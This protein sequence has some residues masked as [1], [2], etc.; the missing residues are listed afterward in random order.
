L[1]VLMKQ[2]EDTVGMAKDITYNITEG[3]KGVE[4]LAR[5]SR[6]LTHLP[7]KRRLLYC[8]LSL[9]AYLVLFYYLYPIIGQPV[10]IFITIPIIFIPL[11]FGLWP[12]LLLAFVLCFLINPLAFALLTD[13]GW[14][15]AFGGAPMMGNLAGLS[16]ALIIAMLRNL[17]WD[18]DDLNAQQI[19]LN[20]ELQL[21]TNKYRS[22]VENVGDIILSCT[23][24]GTV[25]YV[26]PNVV[27]IGYTTEQ[28]IDRGLQEF[29][30]PD[31]LA[32]VR[33]D[34]QTTML[35]GNELIA[36]FRLKTA[37]NDYRWF[38]EFGNVVKETDDVVLLHGV[39]RD[40]TERKRA[41]DALR[42]SEGKYRLLA[43]NSADVIM[44]MDMNLKPS[45]ISPSIQRM[46][47]YS[48]EEAL[49][50]HLEGRITPASIEIIMKSFSVG[51][52]KEKQKTGSTTSETLELEAIHKNGSR[53]WTEMAVSFIR[54]SDGMAI[55]VLGTMRDITERK[56]MEEALRQAAA[57]WRQTFD[58]ISDA[59]SIHSKDCRLQRVNM[60]FADTFRM[61]PRG[62]IGKHC[63]E[64]M[65][66]T[67]EPIP[68]CPHQE[69]L[70]TGKPARAEFFEPKLGIHLE[71]T[72]SPIFDERGE[73]TGTVHIARDTT[74][75]K[76]QS[77]QLMMTDRLAS[78]GELAAGAAHELNNPL[79]S[80][81]GFSQLL[82][83]RDVPDDIRED[84]SIIY[85]QAQ[86]A[87]EVVKNLL[88]FAR[89]HT[90][91]KQPNQINRIIE[92]VLSLRAYE[93]KLNNIEVKRGLALDLPEI[94]TD[95]FQMQQVFVNIII[96]AEYFMKEK[97]NGGT[98][99]VT[100]KRQ[101]D[102]VVVSIADDG[103]GIPEEYLGQ[104]FNP[105]FTTKEVGKGTGLGLSICH[106]IVTEHGG[107]IYAESEPGEGATFVIELPISKQSREGVE[108]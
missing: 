52:N 80:V 91:V 90:P 17:V 18:I 55:G 104:I 45:Y 34:I 107:K 11:F 43:D 35:T 14:A 33:E 32:Q 2:K 61:E 76:R 53:I 3:K 86:R 23:S 103:P 28:I 27:T 102:T 83:E 101:N 74:E 65:H 24:D 85:S 38:E 19:G 71:V 31:D 12:S 40:I 70:R 26:S 57:E 13:A 10:T 58:S 93:H 95:Y 21:I 5:I 41:Q 72:T 51:L 6:L 92:D 60:A 47:G 66:G 88:T 30:H 56:K 9:A 46:L 84:V 69:T 59:I 78:I 64:L 22:I 67:K 15:Q 50:G 108:Q 25:K 87:A 20:R 54:G 77:E 8:L 79:T 96:N 63:H 94:M 16:A 1:M 81:I 62:L 48:A 75:R 7:L 29:I 4:T 36:Q 97:H 89:K 42:V 82:M 37:S 73:I 106:G 68:A 39:L 105:F 100:T 49:T 44:L 99:T 98:L